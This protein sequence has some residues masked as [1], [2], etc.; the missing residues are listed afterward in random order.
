M[1][2]LITF[3]ALFALMEQELPVLNNETSRRA[4]YNWTSRYDDD[5]RCV[6][7]ERLCD[8]VATVAQWEGH[9][10]GN[11]SISDLSRARIQANFEERLQ[12]DMTDPNVGYT[13]RDKELVAE[14]FR[15][16]LPPA[17]PPKLTIV[18]SD[19]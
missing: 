16:N 9:Y 14:Y 5:D 11:Y 1:S 13:E 19:T 6:F 15:I 7:L 3:D 10:Q 17:P 12:D 18:T 2:E 4:E 8:A